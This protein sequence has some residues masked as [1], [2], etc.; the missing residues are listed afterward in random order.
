MYRKIVSHSL[1]K[2][3]SGPGTKQKKLGL[4]P[5]SVVYTG[6]TVSDCRLFIADYGPDEVVHFEVAVGQDIPSQQAPRRWIQVS[7]L[8]DTEF[9]QSL[10]KQYGIPELVLEDVVNPHH[11]AKIEDCGNFLFLIMKMPVFEKQSESLRFEHVSILL[12]D[13][14]VISFQETDMFHFEPLKQ[15][16]DNPNARMR[17]HG[18]DYF[19]YAM[20]DVVVDTYMFLGDLFREKM[21]Q[22]E[23]D[24]MGARRK[25]LVENI[26]LIK[27][28]I[29]K[30]RKATRP[31]KAITDT[32]VTGDVPHFS[33]ALEPFLRDLKD[34]VHQLGDVLENQREEAMA[35]M[36][37]YLSL[38]SHR[39]NEV[40]KILTVVSSIFIP[41][42][43]LAGVYGMNFDHMPELHTRY[44]YFVVVGIMA[45]AAVSMLTLFRLKKWL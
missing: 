35:L 12:F 15:R 33:S 43:F 19:V 6:E 28:M 42:G 9:I 11:N 27:Q 21:D 8:S 24:V 44:G 26:H 1:Y 13:N 34:H 18:C 45:S 32:L 38:M 30:T 29:S 23:D 39:T 14:L 10:G 22:L 25:N 40:M 36:E 3:L 20:L 41:L 31:L 2:G 17:K 37:S 7:G 16:L 5:G 4:A